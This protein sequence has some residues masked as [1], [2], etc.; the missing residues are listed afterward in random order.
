MT[1]RKCTS[2]DG[3]V[4]VGRIPDDLIQQTRRLLDML[5]SEQ[6]VNVKSVS[7]HKWY[8]DLPVDTRAAIDV[9]REHPIWRET[10][11]DGKLTNACKLTN[12]TSMDEVYVSNAP[13]SKQ[14][15]N[16]FGASGNYD[17][18]IDGVFGFPRTRLYRVLIGLTGGNDLVETQFPGL[19]VSKF[20]N[21][22]DFV[23]FDFD[24]SEHKVVN[25]HPDKT[26]PRMM[27]K[28]HFL[29]CE[30]C[31]DAFPFNSKFY[32]DMVTNFYVVYER[33]TRYIM[34][35][36]TDP[37]SLG[38][39]VIGMVCQLWVHHS[40]AVVV[41]VSIALLSIAHKPLRLLVA[42]VIGW[43]VTQVV[44]LWT[45]HR[46]THHPVLHTV[47]AMDASVYGNNMNTFSSIDR[48]FA[49]SSNRTV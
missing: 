39:F 31:D 22:G 18:H 7:H 47:P 8:H 1:D 29:V 49:S 10:L 12:V 48:M 45:L 21:A 13:T 44:F 17:L 40:I 11:C 5:R 25:S 9:V 2:K 43:Y 3:C 27:L 32:N 33:L 19:G 42:I 36:G 16:L 34:H 41:V 14:R 30:Q 23:A 24:R 37:S 20:I 4:S 15:T 28:L 35:E 38:Q 26:V 46:M 6:H